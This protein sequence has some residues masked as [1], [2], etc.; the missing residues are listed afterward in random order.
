MERRHALRLLA[1]AAVSPFVP[2]EL[3]GILQ[4]ARTEVA[5]TATPRTLDPRQYQM[6]T[7]MA[8]IILPET[9]TPGAAAAHVND[10]IDLILT[11]WAGAEERDQF[12]AG[13]ADTDDRSRTKFGKVF[14]EL[15]AGQ[16][17]EIIQL[18]DDE[19]A[20]AMSKHS[21]RINSGGSFF[22]TMKRLTLTGYFTSEAGAKQALHF[23]IIPGRYD[24][25]VP[26]GE[27]KATR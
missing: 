22:H 12:L 24:G 9:D 3:F 21:G 10:F 15:S 26:A 27:T 11:E 20:T 25:C 16:Q 7:R 13:L 6:V 2:A 17:T 23:K 4:A 8:E 19:T 5:T 14:L 18:L 1:T